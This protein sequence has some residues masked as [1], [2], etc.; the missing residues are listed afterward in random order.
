MNFVPFKG[1]VSEYELR[2]A[3]DDFPQGWKLEDLNGRLSTSKQIKNVYLQN[4]MSTY[5]I[6]NRINFFIKSESLRPKRIMIE[7]S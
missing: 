5:F 1:C 6:A 4:S 2:S 7:F 3:G